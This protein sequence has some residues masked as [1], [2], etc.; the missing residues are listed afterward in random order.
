MVKFM[1][2]IP[3]LDILDIFGYQDSLMAWNAVNPE[4]EQPQILSL[5]KHWDAINLKRLSNV[6]GFETDE[7]KASPGHFSSRVQRMASRSS[8]KISRQPFG[9][10]HL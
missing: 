4:T 10:R 2:Q 3:T 6:F 7:G 1:L 9:K 5:Q 8:I